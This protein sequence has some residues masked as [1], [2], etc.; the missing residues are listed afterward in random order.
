MPRGEDPNTFKFQLQCLGCHAV[1]NSQGDLTTPLPVDFSCSVVA[2]GKCSITH[3]YSSLYSSKNNKGFEFVRT[4]I[5]QHC[6]LMQRE[7]KTPMIPRIKQQQHHLCTRGVNTS[8][9]LTLN[10]E[11]ISIPLVV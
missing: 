9:D 2:A 11:N 4:F 6:L 3:G 7:L 5:C 1:E 10:V 8:R